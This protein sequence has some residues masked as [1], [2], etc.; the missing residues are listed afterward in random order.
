MLIGL[1]ILMHML[2]SKWPTSSINVPSVKVPWPLK[3]ELPAGDQVFIHMSLWCACPIQTTTPAPVSSSNQGANS[4][5]RAPAELKSNT[6]RNHCTGGMSL[7]SYSGDMD[8]WFIT[9][10]SH[11]RCWKDV[12]EQIMDDYLSAVGQKVYFLWP[13]CILFSKENLL[14][15]PR[16]HATKQK[17]LAKMDNYFQMCIL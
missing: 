8:I 1:D 16:T 15:C 5:L 12:G 11:I 14:W 4:V 9:T 13:T 10:L 7:I 6:P 17:Q 2:S 3:T